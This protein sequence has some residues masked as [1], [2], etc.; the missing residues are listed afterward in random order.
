M[1]AAAETVPGGTRTRIE[2]TLNGL[3]SVKAENQTHKT[4]Q[5]VASLWPVGTAHSRSVVDT[6]GDDSGRATA[7]WS[8]FRCVAADPL[9]PDGGSIMTEQGQQQPIREP[10]PARPANVIEKKGLDFVNMNPGAGSG[11]A[12]SIPAGSAVDPD[13]GKSE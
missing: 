11:P 5:T 10:R 4:H 12:P 6:P 13:T 3:P 9:P 2:I 8:T 7:R 1:P